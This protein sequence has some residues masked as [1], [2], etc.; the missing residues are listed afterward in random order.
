MT[1]LREE[2]VTL[3]L[4]PVIIAGFLQHERGTAG[5]TGSMCKHSDQEK[6]AA[7]R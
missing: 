3:K 4:L 2:P 6:G 5:I 7:D 1:P